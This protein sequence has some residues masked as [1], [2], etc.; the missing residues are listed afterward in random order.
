MTFKELADL[1]QFPKNWSEKTYREAVAKAT[2]TLIQIG[3]KPDSSSSLRDSVEEVLNELKN[4]EIEFYGQIPTK[5][6]ILEEIK[7][8]DA[9]IA[10]LEQEKAEIEEKIALRR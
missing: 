2:E 10:K 7:E 8:T 3:I 1:A 6:Q 9:E 5:E 4:K